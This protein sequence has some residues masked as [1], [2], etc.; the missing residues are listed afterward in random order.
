[1]QYLSTVRADATR[2]EELDLPRFPN[3]QNLVTAT[4]DD[5]SVWLAPT[6]GGSSWI[7]SFPNVNIPTTAGVSTAYAWFRES[8]FIPER[9]GHGMLKSMHVTC[10]SDSAVVVG[11][12][13]N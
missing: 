13:V 3:T 4:T 7:T 2:A 10:D 8:E 5:K 9:G 6:L 11:K 1:M 12:I